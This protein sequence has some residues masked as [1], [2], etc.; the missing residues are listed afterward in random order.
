MLAKGRRASERIEIELSIEVAGT[1]CMGSE[2]VDRVRTRVIGRH[3]TKF[4]LGRKL[5]A[6]Q[7]VSLRC[8]A[9]GL[10]ADARVVGQISED[11]GSYA[12]GVEFLNEEDNI[13]DIDFPPLSDS[14]GAIGR[15][16][17][18][19]SSCKS[20]EVAYLDDFELEV[21]EANGCL[22]RMCKRCRDASL[23]RKSQGEVPEAEAVTPLPSPS[24]QPVNKR[25]EPRREMRVTACVRSARLGEDLVQ[26]RN[27]SRGGLC[28]VSP[29][30]YFKG[31]EIEVAVPYS[32]GGGNIFMLA[33]IVRLQSLPSEGTRIYGVAYQ[34][35]KG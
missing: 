18:A 15:V 11:S 13:W 26:T 12:Y 21:L 8:L 31:D 17:L 16:V 24:A 29:W 35:T 32:H 33:K 30:E 34:Y 23:W 19:C 6:Q 2:F 3:G 7:E 4:N 20:R 28:F 10:E 27:V 25:R 5:A 9:T 14:E 1:D 22:S